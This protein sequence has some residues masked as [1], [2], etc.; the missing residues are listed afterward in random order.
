MNEGKLL[1]YDTPRR[2]YEHPADL[3]VAHFIGSPG[4]NFLPATRA[5]DGTMQIG[6]TAMR[7]H[8]DRPAGS[9]EHARAGEMRLGIRPEY[10]N[11]DPSG[12]PAVV[13]HTELLGSYNLIAL[14]LGG[15]LIKARVPA[16]ERFSEG[17]Q[18]RVRFDPAGC[19]WFDVATG[20]ALDWATRE[21][22]VGATPASPSSAR[23]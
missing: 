19:R 2:V 15:T 20:R 23:V 6:G 21:T 13:E 4:M 17:E 10:V 9:S 11:I 5:D 12:A 1:Q 22:T 16:H 3:F 18:A 8:V 7:L 14:K